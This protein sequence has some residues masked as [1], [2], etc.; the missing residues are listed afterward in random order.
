MPKVTFIK[1]GQNIEIET[2]KTGQSLLEIAQENAVEM[3]S[4]CGGNGV[5]TTCLVQVQSGVENLGPITEREE[6]MGMD[7]ENPE[8]RLG[9][10]CSVDGDCCVELAY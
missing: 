9:C 8:N 4:A 2:D 10:Q 3:D 1:N 7:A 5:C 6:M